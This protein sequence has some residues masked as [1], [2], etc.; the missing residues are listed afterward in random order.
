MKV[1]L[2]AGLFTALNFSAGSAVSRT[3]TVQA[4]PNVSPIQALQR[5]A[6]STTLQP[7]WFTSEF[8][9]LLPQIQA[10]FRKFTQDLGALQKVEAG[11]QNTY[12]LRYARGSVQVAASLNAQGQFEGLRVLQVQP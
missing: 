5:L 8:T 10:S 9:N 2:L 11:G 6:T 12:W 3:N 7:S 4:V 1:Y